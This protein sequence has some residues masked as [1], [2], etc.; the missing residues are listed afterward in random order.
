[1]AQRAA[2]VWA[3]L[4][5]L[6]IAPGFLAGCSAA[7]AGPLRALSVGGQPIVDGASISIHPGVS[8]DFT[9]F[10]VNP[11]T[12]PVTLISAS[13]LPVPGSPPTGQLIHV[14][15]STDNGFA[16]AAEGWPLPHP[17]TRKL[18]GARIGHG[19]SNIIFGI[20]GH[21]PGKDYSTAGLKIR[22]RYRGQ[23]YSVVAW[24]AA[25]ACVTK[26]ITRQ[27]VCPHAADRIQAKVKKMAGESP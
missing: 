14:G 15:I 22:Y 1:M 12:S 26:V 24:S 17:A 19:Q 25:V 6:S 20:T 13:V 21:V 8:A 16:A 9:A 11:L 10:V 7:A 27:P 4:A 3:A 18:A 23:V 2:G 5:V